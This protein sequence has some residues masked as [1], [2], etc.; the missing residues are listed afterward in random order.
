MKKGSDTIVIFQE[1]IRQLQKKMGKGGDED[2][3]EIR[4][5]SMKRFSSTRAKAEIFVVKPIKGRQRE[6]ILSH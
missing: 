3:D 4:F 6:L 2:Y 1:V 5:L